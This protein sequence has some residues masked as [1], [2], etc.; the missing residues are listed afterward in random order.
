M[1]ETVRH[2]SQERGFRSL[3]EREKRRAKRRAEHASLVRQAQHKKLLE[4]QDANQF[5]KRFGQFNYAS[6]LRHWLG[7]NALYLLDTPESPL[8]I[9]LDKVPKKMPFITGK[10]QVPN[11]FSL[12][13]NAK[14]SM[15]FIRRIAEA[16]LCSRT[17][18]LV[19]DYHYCRNL[20]IGAQVLLDII[21]KDVFAFYDRLGNAPTVEKKVGQIRK[22]VDI[23][24]PNTT[25]DFVKK[26]LYSVGSFAI[27]A[28]TH[29]KFPDIIPY[30]LCVHDRQGAFNR[31]KAIERKDIDTTALADYVID[32]LARMNKKLTPAKREDLCVIIGEALINAEEHATTNFRFSI[33]YFQDQFVEGKHTGLFRLVIMNFGKTIYEKFADPNC[34]NKQIV[35]KMRNLSQQYTTKGLLRGQEFEEET[36]WTLYALQ[37]G[38]TSVADRKR[39]HGTIQF[40]D[41]FF[42]LN[43]D[44]NFSAAGSRMTILSGN[45]KIKFDSKYRI[46]K[47]KINGENIKMMTFNESGNIDE[48]P[49]KENV[50]YVPEYFPGTVISARIVL[51]EEDF[52]ANEDI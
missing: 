33:G 20:D 6:V 45:T 30:Q 11:Q 50:K 35:K 39:G 42:N 2:I 25:P 23:A 9:N 37:E 10:F 16:L 21:F 46:Q 52:A 4:R 14:E 48:K 49:D 44:Q 47:L 40:I 26:I 27:H 34:P 18:R 12:I 41:S 5:E 19:L 7:P 31:V 3:A 28:G 38:V 43:G 8:Y 24:E 13:D 36:L 32:S 15:V 51:D 17:Q 1:D 22:G 29:V